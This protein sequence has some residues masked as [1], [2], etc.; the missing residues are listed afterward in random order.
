M[1]LRFTLIL[2]FSF[3]YLTT[4]VWVSAEIQ[5]ITT[6]HTYIMGDNDS[7]N[8][9]R[10]LCFLEAKRKV[11]EKAG[12]FIQSHSVVNNMELTKDQIISY[13]AAILSVETVKEEFGF[14][15]GQ[16][17]ITL[18]VKA[19]VDIEQVKKLV[20]AIVA[21]RS[22]A[23]RVSHQQQQIRQLEGQLQALNSRL[24]TAAIDSVGELRKE[25]T[26]VIENIDE[27]EKKRIIARNRIRE[28]N[29]GISRNSELIK[30]YIS[31]RMTMEEVKGLIGEPLKRHWYRSNRS[32]NK[33]GDQWLYG[34]L[35][36]CFNEPLR[37]RDYRVYEIAPG[38]PNTDIG[39]M[40]LLN[41]LK[42]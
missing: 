18:T 2:L 23:D 31:L 5:T 42:K 37:E 11:L 41:R 33:E 26:V 12:S 24:G 22:L 32:T 34:E 10:Q 40:C 29:T 6:L 21:D 7:R 13:S 38:I 1:S 16:N 36:V 14:N 17:M 3:A 8:D 25:R 4:P 9:A 28:E 27:V 39:D 35:W 15:N 19:E 20:G 30:T